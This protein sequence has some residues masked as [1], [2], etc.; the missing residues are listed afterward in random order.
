MLV[1]NGRCSIDVAYQAVLSE[2]YNIFSLK[3]EQRAALK[4]FLPTPDWLFFFA[5]VLFTRAA[6][7][8]SPQGCCPLTVMLAV[9]KYGRPASNVMDRSFVQSPSKTVIQIGNLGAE[10]FICG[11]LISNLPE[12]AMF[13]FLTTSSSATTSFDSKLQ[14]GRIGNILSHLNLSTSR[15]CLN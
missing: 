10:H 12:V 15:N 2:P 8:C 9:E 4:T 11:A 13:F 3:Q 6:H 7:P 14:K 5:W 1:N